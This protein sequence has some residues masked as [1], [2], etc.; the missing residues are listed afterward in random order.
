MKFLVD[1]DYVITYLKGDEQATRQVSE[2]F[3]QGIA[4]SIVSYMEVYEGVYYGNHQ[5]QNTKVFHRFVRGVQVL[6]I[7]RSIAQR[8]AVL[9][10]HLRASKA[11]KHLAEPRNHYDLFIAA[12]ALHHH[13]TLVTHNIKD[14]ERIPNLTIYQAQ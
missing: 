13:L 10:G 5:A 11:T 8:S 6:G 14:Y 12:T 3:A 7:N 1:S 4:V 2:L 9:R